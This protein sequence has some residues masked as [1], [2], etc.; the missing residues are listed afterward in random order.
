MSARRTIFDKGYAVDSR[1]LDDLLKAESWVPN[2]VSVN[3]MDSV[4]QF[5]LGLQNA[6]SERLAANGFHIYAAMVVDFMHEWE[7]GVWK[8]LLIHL[9][10]ILFAYD[11]SLVNDLDRQ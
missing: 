1:N 5:I 11:P 2:N 3:T 4:K 7:I 10:R 9:I 6:F 8:N